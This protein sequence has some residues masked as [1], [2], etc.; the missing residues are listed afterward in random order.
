[1]RQVKRSADGRWYTVETVDG[2]CRIS[3][4]DWTQDR[5]GHWP[6]VDFEVREFGQKITCPR[7]ASSWTL[8]EMDCVFG[9]ACR[10]RND[11]LVIVRC[12]ACR[13]PHRVRC[14]GF[15]TA[16]PRVVRLMEG[17]ADWSRRLQEFRAEEHRLYGEPVAGE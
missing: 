1:M 8:E 9:R 17:W 14:V 7:C 16:Y 4:P 13:L 12:A 11:F 15:V 6:R 10:Q 3:P 5:N 2:V